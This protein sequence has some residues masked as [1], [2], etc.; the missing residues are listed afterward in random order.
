MRSARSSATSLIAAAL[1]IA[2]PATGFAEGSSRGGLFLR[3]KRHL[4]SDVCREGGDSSRHIVLS[5]V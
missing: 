3:G 4:E 1:L 2:L 5:V